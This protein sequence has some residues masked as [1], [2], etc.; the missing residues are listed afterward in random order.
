MCNVV[1]IKFK[2]PSKLRF[3]FESVRMLINFYIHF[4]PFFSHSKV[5]VLYKINPV[6]KVIHTRV[7]TIFGY[8]KIF[9][10]KIMH[11]REREKKIWCEILQTVR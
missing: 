6:E 10:I 7:E 8:I 4:L 3:F 9:I 11:S 2:V 1:L 5:Q